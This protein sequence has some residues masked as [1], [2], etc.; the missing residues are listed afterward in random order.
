MGKIER[1]NAGLISFFMSNLTNNIYDIEFVIKYNK[2]LK[3]KLSIDWLIFEHLFRLFLYAKIF[4]FLSSSHY[5]FCNL[6]H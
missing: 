5:Y 1:P 3:I 2:M 6:I 4:F